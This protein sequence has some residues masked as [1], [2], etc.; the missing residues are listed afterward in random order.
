MAVFST[1][2]VRW[3]KGQGISL[4]FLFT[5]ALILFTKAYFPIPSALGFQHEF[6][7]GHKYSDYSRDE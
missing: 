3:H 2:N 4:G 5:R 7:G 6:R 1:V